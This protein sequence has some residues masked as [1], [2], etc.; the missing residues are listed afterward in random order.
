I[1]VFECDVLAANGILPFAR[2]EIAITEQAGSSRLVLM[3]H[4]HSPEAAFPPPVLPWLRGY[5]PAPAARPLHHHARQWPRQW[6][7]A[8]GLHRAPDRPTA[9]RTAQKPAMSCATAARRQ[10]ARRCPL[11]SSPPYENRHWTG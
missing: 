5:A 11:C 3:L 6:L 10:S 7:H 2:D 8:R 1:W 4:L 9:K